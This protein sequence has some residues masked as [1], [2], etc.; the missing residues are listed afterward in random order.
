MFITMIIC[1][2]GC[3]VNFIISVMFHCILKDIENNITKLL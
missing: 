3:I 1:V 2:L